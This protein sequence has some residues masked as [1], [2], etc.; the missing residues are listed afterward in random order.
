MK[1]WILAILIISSL[2]FV[3]GISGCVRE[4][5]TNTTSSNTKEVARLYDTVKVGDLSFQLTGVTLQ[6]WAPPKYG[7][8]TIPQEQYTL[9]WTFEITNNG[10]NIENVSDCG[11]LL[12]EDGSQY[13]FDVTLDDADVD[14]DITGHC[15]YY[16]MVP[17]AKIIAYS[18]FY[19]TNTSEAYVPCYWSGS[20]RV[21]Q[22]VPGSKITYFSQQNVGLVKYII[23]KSEIVYTSEPYTPYVFNAS[24]FDQAKVDYIKAYEQRIKQ[25]VS[26]KE[27][28]C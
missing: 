2:V 26:N 21:W 5:S 19:F 24:E 17:G 15:N 25:L 3:M 6:K 27:G 1:N 18:T 4:S 16:T 7:E 11:I 9:F 12:F 22:E 23:D 20:P 13:N 10:E 14:V 8:W 28:L